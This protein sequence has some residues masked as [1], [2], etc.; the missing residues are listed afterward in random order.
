MENKL[1]N[2][3][4]KVLPQKMTLPKELILLY[5]WIEDNNLFVENEDGHRVGFLFS[6]EQLHESSTEEQ[7]EGGT[8]IEFFAGGT[9]N[10][11]Y[12]FGGEENAQ[13]NERLCVFGQTGGEGSECAFWLDDNDELKIV[14]LGSGSGSTLSCI[15]ADNFLEFN[16]LLAIGYDEICWDEEFSLPPNQ[17]NPDFKVLPNLEF[18]NWVKETFNVEIPKTAL[19]IVKYPTSMDDD[20]SED[21]FFNWYQQFI[22]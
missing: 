8:Q 19:E 12:W 7:R 14:H 2:E 6:Q 5:Q 15:L 4:Q 3:L 20:D 21:A 16:Q 22:V 17:L 13:V 10:L 9:E 18:Q 11:K 1:V